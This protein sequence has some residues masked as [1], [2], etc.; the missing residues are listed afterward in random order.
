M[1]AFGSLGASVRLRGLVPLTP[2]TLWASWGL[3]QPWEPLAAF[4]SLGASVRLRGIAP[5]PPRAP[6]WPQAALGAFGSLGA[7]VR[8]RGL[9]PLE[10]IERARGVRRQRE[11]GE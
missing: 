5:H 8:L 3:R 9:V 4:G 1:G 10:G 11:R 7:S 6:L 2:L